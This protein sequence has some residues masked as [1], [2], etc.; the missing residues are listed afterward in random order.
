M[1][2]EALVVYRADLVGAGHFLIV[3]DDPAD[4]RT[5][6]RVFGKY[7]RVRIATTA[8][9]ARA[10]LEEPEVWAGVVLDVMLPDGSGLD[11]LAFLRGRHP[12][13]PVL[14][15]TGHFEADVANR[16]QALRAECVFKPATL[17]NFRA[18]IDKALAVDAVSNDRVARAV[19]ELALRLDLQPRE[20]NVLAF[21]VAEVPRAAMSIELGI[22][23]NTLKSQIKSLLKKTGHASLNDL[24]RDV[25]L[26]AHAGKP[27][28]VI[29]ITKAKGSSG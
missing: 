23:E 3:D 13:L 12:L 28:D 17:E 20:M 26:S 2:R 1:D 10:A 14:V 21:A 8:A 19:A 11:V 9:Q 6:E 29:Q 4:A 22:S 7:R 27:A 24:A 15:L 18:F 25:L 5:I 16:S